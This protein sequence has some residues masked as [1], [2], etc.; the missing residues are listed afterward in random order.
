MNLHVLCIRTWSCAPSSI[1]TY[2]VIK[3]VFP[4]LW[5]PRSTILVR[6]GGEE[7]KSA[8]TGVE[9]ESAMAGGTQLRRRSRIYV[10]R[11]GYQKSRGA[12][13]SQE[14]ERTETQTTAVVTV[15]DEE[16]KSR[17][18]PAADPRGDDSR[19]VPLIMPQ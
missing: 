1:A 11:R 6:L 17:V 16:L 19:R 15:V 12:K 4:T 13:E 18:S 7:E 2:R 3:L 10:Q 8:D 14:N 5:S 9:A